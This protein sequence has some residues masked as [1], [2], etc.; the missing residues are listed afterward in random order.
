MK[1]LLG[2][3]A[4]GIALIFLASVSPAESLKDAVRATLTSNPALRAASEEARASAF[5]L[6][7]FEEDFLPRVTARVEAGAERVD[8]P[9]SLTAADNKD[10]LFT[11]DASLEAEIVLFDGHRRTNR[12][13]AESARVDGNIFRLLDASETMALN[14]TEVYIDVYRHILLQRAAQRN[15]ANHRDIERQVINLVE[16]GRLPLSDRFQVQAQV[17]GAQLLLIEVKRARADANARYKRIVGHA[18][19][20]P[21]SLP[22]FRANVGTLDAFS[23]RVVAN[24]YRVRVAETE[25]NR[26]GYNTEVVDAEKRPRVT[27]NAGLREGDNIDG[28]RGRESDMFLGLRMDWTLYQGGRDAARNAAIARRSKAIA[29][30]NQ[31][32]LEAREL[33]ERT[34]NSNAANTERAVLLDLQLRS[35]RA[36]VRQY[37]DEFEAGK[38]SLLEVLDAE[39]GTFDV[40]FEKISAEASVI[41]SAYRLMAAQSRLAAHFGGVASETAL[42]PDFESRALQRPTSVF[43]TTIAPLD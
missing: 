2:S 11:T 7:K 36:I 3:V 14:A 18:P 38:R 27:L 28:V 15:L 24:S 16:S 5:D 19:T 23:Q 41:F 4:G 43:K 20:D 29:E 17:R 9:S 26:A 25:I 32:I 22:H 13:Y 40:E 39:R 35:N 6:L 31:A 21:M 37:R 1:Q 8:D 34:W 42:M 10:T 30:R 12:V 33:A